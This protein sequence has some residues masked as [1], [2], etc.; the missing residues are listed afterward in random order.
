M[1]K[2][3]KKRGTD[4]IYTGI[5]YMFRLVLKPFLLLAIPLF[6]SDNEQGYWYTF[7]SLAALTT[8]AD[9]GFTTIVSQFAAHET[10]LLQYDEK[11]KVYLGN[12]ARLI[13]LFQTMKKWFG[14]AMLI[15]TPVIFLI[16]SFVMQGDSS[17]TL[18]VV[19]WLIY[20]VFNS[21]NFYIQTNLAFFEGCNRIADVQK[22]KCID[23]IVVNGLSMVLLLCGAGVYALGCSMAVASLVDI[24]LYKKV[25]YSLLKQLLSSCS[26]KVEWFKEIMPLLK[27]YAIGWISNYLTFQLYNPLTFRMFGAEVAGQ[28]GYTITIIS[29]IYSMANIWMYVVT[30]IMNA[31]AERKNWKEM[32]RTLR[33]NLPLSGGTFAL[34]V[35]LFCIILKIPLI[36]SLLGGRILPV[37]QFLVLGAAY[38]LQVFVNGMAIYLRAHKQEP[39]LY[40]GIVSAVC[41][42]VA[43]VI[44]LTV[45]SVDYVFYGYLLS[46]A[47]T[48]PTVIYI[49]ISKRKE[50]HRVLPE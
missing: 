40:V 6:L 11:E 7:T 26:E 39:L 44:I 47:I 46:F 49:F 20:A 27:R 9:L 19:P 16:G 22:I 23:A 8:F 33:N 17:F 3:L 13:S 29:S 41:S 32:D 42:I 37:R 31:Q 45:Y 15:I 50:W 12:D 21:V 10:A 4:I 35:V 43:T 48:M 36:D 25:F 30:P 5:N 1:L 2:I 18:Y 38:F 28:V 24:I 14:R 34:G